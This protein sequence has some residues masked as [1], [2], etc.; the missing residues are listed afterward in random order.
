MPFRLELYSIFDVGS[1]YTKDQRFCGHK[2][3]YSGTVVFATKKINISGR[4]PLYSGKRLLYCGKVASCCKQSQYF[5]PLTFI[6]WQT[7][8]IRWLTPLIL[9]DKAFYNV[10]T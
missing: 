8:F 9:V 5:W 2:P 6:Q 7:P 3:L 1:C 10:A 4:K